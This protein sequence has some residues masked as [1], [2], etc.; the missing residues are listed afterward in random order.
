MVKTHYTPLSRPAPA[1]ESH[2]SIQAQTKAFLDRGGENQ[3]VSE[4]MTGQMGI[5]TK[6][7]TVINTPVNR[8]KFKKPALKKVCVSKTLH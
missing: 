8:F 4:G 6:N 1:R 7:F 5:S 2:Q 3:S